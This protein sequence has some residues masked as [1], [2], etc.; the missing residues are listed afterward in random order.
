MEVLAP[1]QLCR[2]DGEGNLTSKIIY[3]YKFDSYGNWTESISLPAEQIPNTG[4][5]FQGYYRK[6]TYYRK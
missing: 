6:L 2:Y 1:V 5:Q 4:E 3:K